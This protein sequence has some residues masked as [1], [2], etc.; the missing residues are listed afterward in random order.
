VKEHK[1]AWLEL[2]VSLPE[3][4]T[5]LGAEDAGAVEDEVQADVTE[6]EL[7]AEVVVVAGPDPMPTRTQTARSASPMRL[8]KRP[9]SQSA[10]SQGFQACRVSIVVRNS[11]ARS[12]Q[13]RNPL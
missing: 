2:P 13:V 7:V 12:S 9:T 3:M 6:P 5:V 4:Q 10:P 8:A 1:A 11:S